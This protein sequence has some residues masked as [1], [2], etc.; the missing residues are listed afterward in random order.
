MWLP[1]GYR[2]QSP[3][4]LA[5]VI[6]AA[7]AGLALVLLTTNGSEVLFAIPFGIVALL[8]LLAITRGGGGSRNT[9]GR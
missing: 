1:P 5:V 7:L 2:R 8:C 6:V 3:L 4:A 9:A